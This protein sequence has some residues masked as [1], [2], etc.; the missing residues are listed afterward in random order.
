MVCFSLEPQSGFGLAHLRREPLRVLSVVGLVGLKLAG[1]NHRQAL[2][3]LDLVAFL[4]QELRNQPGDLR[5]D[6][7]VVGRDDT[8][9]H[10]RRRRPVEV[11]VEPGAGAEH[12]DEHEEAADAFHEGARMLKH[13]YKTLV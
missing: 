4:D 2:V 1:V 5:A 6:D 3:L 7:D 13:L 12:D 10:E 8:G 9:Q 11:G